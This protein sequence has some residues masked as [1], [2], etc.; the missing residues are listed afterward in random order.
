MFNQGLLTLIAEEFS[1]GEVH[2]CQK[3][4]NGWVSWVVICAFNMSIYMQDDSCTTKETC[5]YN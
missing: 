2:V 1:M 3:Q 4:A 5:V